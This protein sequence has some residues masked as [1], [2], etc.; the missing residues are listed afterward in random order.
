MT[1]SPVGLSAVILIVKA[2]DHQLD[3]LDHSIMF[4]SGMRRRKL[5]E[6]H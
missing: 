4:H 2:Q 1:N 5:L 3:G 6:R